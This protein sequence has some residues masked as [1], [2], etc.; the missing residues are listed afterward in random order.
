MK[1]S[2]K[3]AHNITDLH[4]IAKLQ[5]EL[6]ETKNATWRADREAKRAL[7]AVQP[8]YRR[9]V[10]WILSIMHA[11]VSGMLADDVELREEVITALVRDH[12]PELLRALKAKPA[13]RAA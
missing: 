4:K 2:R 8:E 13:K 7:L 6:D 1:T 10:T 9:H 3:Q 12:R 5:K 11:M